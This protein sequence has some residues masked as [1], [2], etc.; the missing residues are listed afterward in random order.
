MMIAEREPQPGIKETV[1]ILPG[2]N[3][4]YRFGVRSPN[5]FDGEVSGTAHAIMARWNAGIQ[6]M[7]SPPVGID[8]IVR[9]QPEWPGKQT[10]LTV[11]EGGVI[12]A[13]NIKP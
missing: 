9:T 5:K 10:R 3:Y 4:R 6:D 13:L 7:K 2:G 11:S 1:E 8:G 12:C